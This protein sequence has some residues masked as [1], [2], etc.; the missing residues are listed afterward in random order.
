MANIIIYF[1]SGKVLEDDIIIKKFDNMGFEIHCFEDVKY[2]DSKNVDFEYIIGEIS[3][4]D[5]QICLMSDEIRLIG[6][7]FEKYNWRYKAFIYNNHINKKNE[8][9]RF[10]QSSLLYNFN[11]YC[12]NKINTNIKADYI[13]EEINFGI[14][15][16]KIDNFIISV[17][18]FIHNNWNN[19]FDLLEKKAALIEKEI[20][21][22]ENDDKNKVKKYIIINSRDENSYFKIYILTFLIKVFKEKED[23]KKALELILKEKNFS[24]NTKYFLLYQIKNTIFSKVIEKDD[25]IKTLIHN[26]YK[27]VYEYYNHKTKNYSFISKNDR[28]EELIF[29]IISQFL[30]LN[31]G[32]T[33]TVLDRIYVLSQKLKKKVVLLNTRECLSINDVIPIYKID[34]ANFIE[35]YRDYKKIM[36][37]DIEIP[38]YQSQYATP[39]INE[40]NNILEMVNNLKPYMIFG[41]GELVLSCDLCSKIVPTI[42]I[43][44]G[45]DLPESF[46][47]FKS[48]YSDNIK[49]DDESI[50]SS[51]FTFDF[52]AQKNTYTRKQ[53]NIPENQFVIGVV[54]G[55]LNVEIDEE[56]LHVLDYACSKGAFVVFI[57]GYDTENDKLTKYINLIKNSS[58]LGYQKD[59]LGVL[60]LID[61]YLNPKRLGGGTSGL[62]ALYKGKPVISLD[63]GDVAAVVGKDFVVD[64]FNEMIILIDK[65]MLN[66]E[67]YDNMSKKGENIASDLM[68]TE[69]YFS[70]LY[71]KIKTSELF[72]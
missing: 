12:I 72:R 43:P 15:N 49:Y 58:N 71:E 9:Y 54:G 50:I 8:K 68:N 23:V 46:T 19:N 62:E 47:T 6:E 44:L 20:S 35:K 16:N 55:R 63:Y 13:R 51:K 48:T 32:P 61:L 7:L 18:E 42:S 33:K 29:V 28:N 27:E 59:V 67:F 64:D 36:Y 14:T 26:V 5:E 52:K 24:V 4:I 39:D 11:F 38:F 30:D 70:I 21:E 60:D 40:Y 3:N 56:F 66:T 25:E 22:L 53:F 34:Q 17:N 1:C 10:N 45:N 69:K 41:I 57:G 65:Y 2:E 37:K 31:N